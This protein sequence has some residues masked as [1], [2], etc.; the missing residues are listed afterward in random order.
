[1]K[2]SDKF[3]SVVYGLKKKSDTVQ[4][5]KKKMLTKMAWKN[6]YNK[7]SREFI[8]ARKLRSNYL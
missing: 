2:E 8:L 4:Q 6:A 7:V 1:M 3:F 5:Q